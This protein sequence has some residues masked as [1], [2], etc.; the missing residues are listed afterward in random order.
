V[1]AAAGQLTGSTAK[2]SATK[3]KKRR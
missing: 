3:G 1:V 2:A